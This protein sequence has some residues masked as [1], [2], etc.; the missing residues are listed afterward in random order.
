[1]SFKEVDDELWRKIR[2]YM[3]SQKPT[4]GRPRADLRTTFNG[5]LYV[6]Y[7]GCRWDEVPK[8]YGAKSTVH[9]LHLKLA[10]E[11]KYKRIVD[12]LLSEGYETGAI[13]LSLSFVDTKD[14]PAKK[15]V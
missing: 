4:I 8:K 14:I 9:R 15:G 1:M 2:Y 7:T 5:I 3:P 11:G 10:K 12:I 13:D 6:L